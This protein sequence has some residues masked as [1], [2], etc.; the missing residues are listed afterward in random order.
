MMLEKIGL[1]AMLEQTAEEC[2][3]LTKA[4]LTVVLDETKNA[5]DCQK[6]EANLKEEYTDVMQC[7]EELNLTTSSNAV[8]DIAR[9]E[10]ITLFMLH[11]AEESAN[12]GKAA[13]KLA[14]IIR[15][16][17][18]TPVTRK[19]AVRKLR[20]QYSKV[21]FYGNILNISYDEKQKVEKQK[22]FLKRWHKAQK[23]NM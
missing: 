5:E 10:T 3:E 22:R 6:A 19:E 12:F 8:A 13:L 11:L 23:E 17:N 21:F 2:T 15:K 20:D 9:P 7:C 18:P 4:A 1:P 14:R 16:E